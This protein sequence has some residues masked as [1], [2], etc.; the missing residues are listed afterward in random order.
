MAAKDKKRD[1]RIEFFIEKEYG[2]YV[3]WYEGN[4]KNAKNSLIAALVVVVICALCLVFF[5]DEIDPMSFFQYTFDPTLAI[6]IG[7][8]LSIG[9]AVMSMASSFMQRRRGLAQI[10][11]L[12]QAFS[13]YDEEKSD[14]SFETF[15]SHV[16]EIMQAANPEMVRAVKHHNETQKESAED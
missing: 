15:S 8:G 3:A 12:Q 11:K 14:A 2:R 4:A 7:L 13:R 16:E 5:P 10:A 9:L 6:K 1:N